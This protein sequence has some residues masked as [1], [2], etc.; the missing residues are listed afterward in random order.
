MSS[1]SRYILSLA[2]LALAGSLVFAVASAQ[3]TKPAK[4][5]VTKPTK[6]S[7]P[8]PQPPNYDALPPSQIGIG[9]LAKVARQGW[10]FEMQMATGAMSVLAH[11]SYMYQ[12][13]S[14]DACE[15]TLPGTNQSLA[16]F[17]AQCDAD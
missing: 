13:K 16:D 15:T 17:L 2:A 4:P 14:G 5:P 10:T 9:T 8:R 1:L 7:G 3:Q 12:C 6:P 11:W